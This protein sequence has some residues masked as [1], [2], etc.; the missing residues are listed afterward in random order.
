MGDAGAKDVVILGAGLAGLTAGRVLT[1][2]GADLEILEKDPQVGG[3]ARTV[4]HHGFRFD[5]GGHRFITSDE[6]I[7]RLVRDVLDGEI[8]E[9]AR[10]SKILHNGRYFDYPLN[11]RNAFFG[12]G[13]ATAVR[14]VLE[15]AGVRLKHRFS[16]ADAVSLE[17]WVVSRFGRTL[18]SIFF[19]D[20]SEKVWG[21]AC[22]RICKEWVEQRIQNLSLG[23]ALKDAFTRSGGK[24]ARTLARRFLYPP[25]GIGKIAEGLQAQIEQSNPIVTGARIVRLHRQGN[26]IEKVTV[27]SGDETREVRGQDVISSIPLTELVRLLSPKP[28]DRVLDAASRVRFRD[29]V[30]VAVMIDRDRVTDETWI[31]FPEK[32]TPFGRLHEPTN[33]SAEMAPPGKTLLV[34]ERFCFRGDETWTARDEDLAESTVTCLSGLGLVQKNEVVGHAVIRIPNAYPLFEVGYQEFHGT[35]CAY[36]EEIENLHLAGRGG[37]FRYYNMDHAME[38]GL[39]AAE[40]VISSVARAPGAMGEKAGGDWLSTGTDP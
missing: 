15:Y 19:K 32:T 5:L 18:F 36:L 20:Y 6:R 2:A 38:S 30:I 29:L 17:D 11:F 22:D 14:I 24:S 35:I 16:K 4:D 23:K 26:R 37:L 39:A 8:L 12:L 34:T 21:I 13:P 25:Q 3:L 33:W 7:E 10:S 9:V 1:R 27:R 31:Y 40:A 28:P